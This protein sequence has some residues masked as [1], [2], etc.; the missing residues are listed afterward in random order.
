M[1]AILAA[2]S[3]TAFVA[4]FVVAG[5]SGQRV[6][7]PLVVPSVEHVGQLA[8][9][10]SPDDTHL[11]SA[12][13]DPHVARLLHLPVEGVTLE[14]S[15]RI[16][17]PIPAE[18]PCAAQLFFPLSPRG[19]ELRPGRRGLASP[20]RP[21]P[22]APGRALRRPTHRGCRGVGR[23]ARGG[24]AGRP[25]GVDRLD[26]VCRHGSGRAIQRRAVRRVGDRDVGL[27]T[28][29]TGSGLVRA[30]RASSVAPARE[31]RVEQGIEAWRSGT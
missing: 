16:H 13:Q 17:A 31:V 24:T 5:R 7:D 12:A 26:L 21:A 3:M 27:L 2:R 1:S 22:V 15:T 6:L 8:G 9:G 28:M 4:V 18:R 29:T 11:A 14:P 23:P 25:V 30:I 20:K 19:R 10:R